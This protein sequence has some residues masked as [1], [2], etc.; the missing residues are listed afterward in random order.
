MTQ[1]ASFVLPPHLGLAETRYGTM[2][3]P[4]G[5][6][7]VGR[8][9][10]AYGEYSEG[11]VALFRQ[12]VRPGDVVVEAGANIGALTL[13]LAQLAG[14]TGRVLAFEPQRP[15]HQVLSA[16]LLINGLQSVA[17]ERVALGRVQGGI[18][19]PQL[20]LTREQNFGG[21][22]LDGAAGEACP[23]VP[24]DSL[25][26][27]ALRLIKADVEGAELEVLDGARDTI[28]RLRPIL[29]LENDRPD[30]SALL[31]DRV[32]SFG[33]RLWWHVVPLFNSANHRGNA[34]NIFGGVASF[35]VICV[36]RESGMAFAD[37]VE[38][39]SPDAPHPL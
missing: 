12:I 30:N 5:D 25:G 17:A 22:S 36:P 39:F 21:L 35:N 27:A 31:I 38:I 19:V 9:L 18:R 2:I 3:F 11:E 33:Y 24:L 14:P 37:G 6:V 15:I 13:P 23:V 32:L 10:A 4:T 34:K 20:D 29:Y 16:N 1:G 28:A 8:S 26:L 7:W